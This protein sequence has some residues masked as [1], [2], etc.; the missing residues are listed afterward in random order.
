[1]TSVVA[2]IRAAVSSCL[3]TAWS[4]IRSRSIS[5]RRGPL[6]T[7]TSAQPVL[8]STVG[9][10][11][12]PTAKNDDTSPTPA[13][14]AQMA[15]NKT[16]VPHI[17]LYAKHRLLVSPQTTLPLNW[18]TSWAV[19]SDTPSAITCT[20]KSAHQVFCISPPPILATRWS[21]PRL[22]AMPSCA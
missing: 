17:V 13:S 18:Y 12:E 3:M 11:P 20:E 21:K 9:R 1:M 6:L 5:P 10:L 7:Q 15:P 22:A 19:V 4:T 8:C 14:K 2:C 16:L